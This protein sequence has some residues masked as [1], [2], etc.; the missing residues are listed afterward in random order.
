MRLFVLCIGFVC[1]S[2]SVARGE[3]PSD[4]LIAALIA[5]E[6]GGDDNARGDLHLRQKAYGCLQIRQPVC[7]DINRR[8]GTRLRAEQMLG[9]RELSISVCKKYIA[10]YATEKNLGRRPEL[11]DMARIWNGGPCGFKKKSTLA[12]REKVRKYL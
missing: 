9:N 4:K 2:G 12:Y 5:V 6:S 8:Y 1:V 11:E 7:D 10:M 3:T